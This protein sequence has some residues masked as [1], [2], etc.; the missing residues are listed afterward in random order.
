M[1]IQ[2]MTLNIPASFSMQALATQSGVTIGLTLLQKSM[3]NPTLK[4]L[5]LPLTF[6]T[7]G[8]VGYYSGA[9]TIA[10]L[11]TTALLTGF[12]YYYLKEKTPQN[13]ASNPT[14]SP[15]PPSVVSR[16]WSDKTAAE[17]TSIIENVDK[18][19][20]DYERQNV[21][22]GSYCVNFFKNEEPFTLSTHGTR[23]KG[24]PLLGSPATH[25]APCDL[26]KTDSKKLSADF[27]LL[28]SLSNRPLI[29]D[30]TSPTV[31]WFQMPKEKQLK[32]LIEAQQV[33]KKLQPLIGK[34]QLYLELHC[35][36]NAG[37]TQWHTHLRFELISSWRGLDWWDRIEISN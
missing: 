30:S 10:N 8:A 34:N 4:K 1:S 3:R 6:L 13:R 37:Q 26:C 15:N 2:L 5:Q 9:A 12:A 32:M 33:Q 28:R 18:L 20:Q 7:V 14:I 31:N 27:K 25:T 11:I 35:G 36:S 29:I 24:T 21:P 22:P 17:L 19:Y 16:N 23:A